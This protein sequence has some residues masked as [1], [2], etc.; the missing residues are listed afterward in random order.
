MAV[1]TGLKRSRRAGGLRSE[2]SVK[3]GR[4]DSTVGRLDEAA[5]ERIARSIERDGGE[6]S[7]DGAKSRK[8]C[9]ECVLWRLRKKRG[10]FEQRWWTRQRGVKVR[11]THNFGRARACSNP[12]RPS[13]T[14]TPIPSQWALPPT[15]PPHRCANSTF[16]HQMQRSPS[17]VGRHDFGKTSSGYSTTSNGRY[18]VT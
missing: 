4:E 8:V 3:T 5:R 2:G 11:S 15:A 17:Q 6:E 12:H 1:R 13:N 14:A 10:C 16:N 9:L 18:S 7:L